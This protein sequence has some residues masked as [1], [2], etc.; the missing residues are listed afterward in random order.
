MAKAYALKGVLTVNGVDF[1]NT[2]V[3][4]RFEREKIELLY[5]GGNG[6]PQQFPDGS[7]KLTGSM[8]FAWDSDKIADGELPTPM[9]DTLGTFVANVGAKTIAFQAAIYDFDI[10]K[11][12]QGLIT[13]TCSFESS[14]AVTIT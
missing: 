13:C 7:K 4:L 14:G 5:Q 9:A 1:E 10:K 11:G 6:W 2:S 3:N 8:E 12:N